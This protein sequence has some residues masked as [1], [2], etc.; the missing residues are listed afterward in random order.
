[1]SFTH[2]NSVCLCLLFLN[3]VDFQTTFVSNWTKGL[4]DNYTL[5][6]WI[7]ERL[8]KGNDKKV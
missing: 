2:Q 3:N 5:D 7:D 6:K 8:G 1:M 4:Q